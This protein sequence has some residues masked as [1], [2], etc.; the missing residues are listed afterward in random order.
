MS[1]YSS[2]RTSVR[3]AAGPPRLRLTIFAPL[4][5]AYAIAAASSKS[6]NIP[7]ELALIVISLASPAIPAIPS[8]LEAEPAASEATKVP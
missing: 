4:S 6:V 1:A 3:D 7:A 8:P 2:A 5:T